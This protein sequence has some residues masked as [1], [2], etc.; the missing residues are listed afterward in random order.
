M[1]EVAFRF[2]HRCP[3][4]EFSKKFPKAR[5]AVWDNFQREF[6]DVRAPDRTDW[7]LMNRELASFARAKGSKILHKVSDGRSYRLQIMTCTCRRTGSTPDLIMKNDCLFVPPITYYD[8]WETYHVVAF[9]KKS[10]PRLLS[11]FSSRGKVELVSNKRI[12]VNSLHQSS[13]MPL[14]DPLSSLTSLQ[15]NA[16]ITSMALGYYHQP[17]R[18]ST[19]KIASTLKVPRTTFQEHRKKAES[20]LMS[21]LAPYV[22][23]YVERK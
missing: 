3:F 8:G 13:V 19:G 23:T 5:I 11:K 14:L 15:L 12:E 6:M 16:L 10:I 1:Y 18:T 22:L 17:R 2:Q 9:D 7:P 21:A 4:N 20:K